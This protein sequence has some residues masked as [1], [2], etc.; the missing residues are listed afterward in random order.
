MRVLLA[1]TLLAS[2]STPPKFGRLVM[3]LE[4]DDPEAQV[5]QLEIQDLEGA[6][7]H[8]ERYEL[9]G[10]EA[11]FVALEPG[12]VRVLMRFEDA[13]DNYLGYGE[14]Q[15]T[16]E[17][18]GATEAAIPWYPAGKVV[19]GEVPEGLDPP[20][21]A[22][23]Y[24][25]DPGKR[26]TKLEVAPGPWAVPV[27]RWALEVDWGGPPPPEVELPAE[28]EVD[29]ADNLEVDIEI[30]APP[31]AGIDGPPEQPRDLGLAPD[32]GGPLP[33]DGGP[34]PNCG[35]EDVEDG[36][37]VLLCGEDGETVT[38]A[39][40]LFAAS[41]DT[42]FRDLQVVGGGLETVLW[43]A[44]LDGVRR[45][46]NPRADWTLH[47]TGS[48][49]AVRQC[50]DRLYTAGP[51]GLKTWA[52]PL[53]VAPVPTSERAGAARRLACLGGGRGAVAATA[54][55]A[56]LVTDDG[57]AWAQR[58]AFP[59]LPSVLIVQDDL[60]FA[61]D[62]EGNLAYS[63]DG[64]DSFERPPV[65]MDSWV[66]AATFRPEGELVIAISNGESLIINLM[67][68]E[69]LACEPPQ[70]WG[71]PPQGYTATRFEGEEPQ[72]GGGAASGTDTLLAA[73][74]YLY[75]SKAADQDLVPFTNS[76]GFVANYVAL[77][78]YNGTIL[79]LS[80]DRLLHFAPDL[81]E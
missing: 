22:L 25:G 40:P 6:Q 79:A 3:A 70:G 57:A 7:L 8:F 55:G 24:I 45:A 33:P 76:G 50:G 15:V 20:A 73:G 27:G 5:M 23:R 42:R 49:E 14:T 69:T 47:E 32:Q 67:R 74:T 62:R 39:V 71:D 58:T 38:A 26:P 16:V 81:R 56:I 77:E 9:G 80:E 61:A 35:G 37:P 75:W 41:A 31:D 17:P 51:E 53:A 44:G 36:Q 65:L 60:V 30:G 19:F 64:G 34:P 29:R 11:I 72:G 21:M 13:G 28:L 18:Q 12:E 63:A 4:I 10:S 1:M 78:V 43:V 52:L 68:C 2:C 54:D 48:T 66:A 46:E 59:G